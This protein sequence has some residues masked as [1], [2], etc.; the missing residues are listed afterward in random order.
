[1]Q[2]QFSIEPDATPALLQA[3]RLCFSYPQRAL[4]VDCTLKIPP[5]I[6]LLR[7][8]DGS[9][10]TT[11]LRLL[12]GELAASAGHLQANGIGSAD[13][14]YRQQVLRTDPRSDAWDQ[15]TPG[16][17]FTS[18]Q[19]RYPRFDQQALPALVDALALAPHIDK[20]LH[21]LSTGSKR[22]VWLA[23]AFAS[24]AAVT[25]LDEPFAALD[26]G[27]VATL[28]ALLNAAAKANPDRAW[29][30]ADYAAPAGIAMASVIDL[31]D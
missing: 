8:G 11:L 19:Q 30:L 20:Q 16:A 26:R 18:V 17:C 22:K 29:V 2:Q 28:V 23:A 3:A 1:M 21:M 7:G 24:H 4:F 25:L 13:P 6:T 10:K 9:G 14:A 5:G 12:A 31:G 15:M 27:S